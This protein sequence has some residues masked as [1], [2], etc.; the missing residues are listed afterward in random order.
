MTDPNAIGNR[1]SDRHRGWLVFDHLPPDLQRAEDATHYRD[2]HDERDCFNRPATDTERTL[3][4]HLGFTV[5]EQLSTHI[6]HVTVGI[7]RRRW[8]ALEA[9]AQLLEGISE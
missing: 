6:D 7:V 5:P 3:L 2:I 4:A 8:P 9:N 1:I